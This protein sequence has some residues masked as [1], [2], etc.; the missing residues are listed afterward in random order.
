[1]SV[2]EELHQEPG[3]ISYLEGDLTSD[4]HEF[5]IDTLQVNYEAKIN[6]EVKQ[7]TFVAKNG[8]RIIGAITVSWVK[9][10]GSIMTMAV[11]ADF[12]GQGIGKMLLDLAE[13]HL[14]KVGCKR[15]TV[16]TMD[17]EAPEFYIK[18]GYKEIG[19]I[20]DYHPGYDYIWLRCEFMDLPQSA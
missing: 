18:H 17:F 6:G 3:T 10:N 19:R 11:E 14:Y 8:V 20:K 9:E 7:W 15:V 2:S 1:M 12:R 13:E 4:V 16:S 5:L